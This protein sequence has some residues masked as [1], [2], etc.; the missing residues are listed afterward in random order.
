MGSVLDSTN[1]LLSTII[2]NRQANDIRKMRELQEKNTSN[3][4]AEKA[5]LEIIAD[6]PKEDRD[7]IL[8]SIKKKNKTKAKEEKTSTTNKNQSTSTLKEIDSVL[9]SV[10][11]EKYT[12]I[13]V[14]ML[15]IF[16]IMIIILTS[17]YS[18]R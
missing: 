15:V 1:D 14:V 2:R 4:D 18:S 17:V 5:L 13:A 12:I 10:P 11:E 6:L 9:A 8:D 7:K 3:G 16:V